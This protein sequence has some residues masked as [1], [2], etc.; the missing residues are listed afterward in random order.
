MSRRSRTFL[1]KEKPQAFQ[2][3]C[4]WK[5]PN[6]FQLLTGRRTLDNGVKSVVGRDLEA[7]IDMIH[8]AL[9][10]L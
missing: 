7:A 6:E 10:L 4:G 3:A 9:S 2:R 8:V 5:H 1:R